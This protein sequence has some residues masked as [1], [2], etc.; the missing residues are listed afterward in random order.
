M[1]KLE[2]MSEPERQSWLTLLA[3]GAV[4]IY[5]WQKM[6]QGFGFKAQS[7][8]PDEIGEIFLGVVI[9]TV[10]LHA[11]IAA[12]FDMRKR[13]DPF[14]ED[15]RDVRIAGHG[16]DIGYKALQFGV[17]AIIITL[18]LQYIVGDDFQSPFSVI[19]PVEMIFA[20]CVISYIADLLKHGLQIYHYRQ[21]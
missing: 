1:T 17:G 18:V 2:D 16:N 19:E 5:V 15:E 21:S 11:S 9:V 4:F 6:T 3:D 7:F 20:L 10:I 13:K 14:E 8:S 12:I